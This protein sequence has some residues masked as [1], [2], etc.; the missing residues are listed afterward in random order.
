MGPPLYAAEDDAMATRRWS[1]TAW[2]QWGRR[3]TRRKT[4]HA[5]VHGAGRRGFNGAAA[6]RGGRLFDGPIG[7][8]G[9]EVLQWGRRS[10]RRKTMSRCWLQVV[11]RLA[12]MGPPLYAAEDCPLP[13]LC[14][15]DREASMGP[16]LYA[17]EDGQQP[18]LW[19]RGRHASM[20]PPLYAAE[21]GPQQRS[22]HR[23]MV[24]SMGPPLY[25]AEDLRDSHRAARHMRASMGP[26]LYAAE[27]RSWFGCQSSD[28]G[29]M[30]QWGRR[31]TRRKTR[32]LETALFQCVGQRFSRG[33]LYEARGNHPNES[34]LST[35][36]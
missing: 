34:V 19:R 9:S 14:R 17:A 8:L 12:S 16:P 7:A 4:S 31:S 22:V 20:G 24:A 1:R 2:L 3:S 28:V 36:S 6:L 29:H 27:D 13:A 15:F 32:R 11:D 35:C 18:S 25:A 33:R 5:S 23:R 30:L 10:T 21:D 26:P